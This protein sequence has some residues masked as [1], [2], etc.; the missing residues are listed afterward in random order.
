MPGRNNKVENTLRNV[1]IIY[2]YIISLSPFV[3]VTCRN[4]SNTIIK[5]EVLFVSLVKPE[6]YISDMKS[7]LRIVARIVV[8]IDPEIADKRQGTHASTLDSSYH[9]ASFRKHS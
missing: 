4:I 9:K 3:D 1:W 7:S 8:R 2:F 6:I 5:R